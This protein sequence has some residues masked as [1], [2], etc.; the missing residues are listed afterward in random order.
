MTVEDDDAVP[1]PTVAMIAFGVALVAGLW[2]IGREVIATVGTHL[3]EMSPAAGFTA[4][5]SAAMVVMLAS[6][7]G[8]PV[9][10]THILVGAILG[11]GLV[12]RN[13]NWRLM[14]P[15]ALAWL[16][17]VPAAGLCA[18]LAFVLFNAVF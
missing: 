11:I 13:A 15:I 7:L 10:S 8:L 4:E 18:A 3:A 2:F 16:I 14:K 12:N 17:T 1:V 6:S 9:S 5:L